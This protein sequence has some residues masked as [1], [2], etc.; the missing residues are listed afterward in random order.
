MPKVLTINK[1]AELREG[2]LAGTKGKLVAYDS[3]ENEVMLEI[4]PNVYVTCPSEYV[5]QVSS[6]PVEEKKPP[7]ENRPSGTIMKE[8]FRFEHPGRDWFDIN[9]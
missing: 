5:E 9:D 6:K 4:E 3:L 7:K 8:D 2:K 1:Q